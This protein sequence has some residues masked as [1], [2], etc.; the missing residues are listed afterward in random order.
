MGTIRRKD[1]AQ[2]RWKSSETLR[3]GILVKLEAQWIVG[4]VDGE[5]CF[6]VSINKN[7]T[8]TTG[9][10]VL[11]EFTVVQHEQDVKV[12]HALK[13]YFGCGVVRVNRKDKT[14]TRMAYRVRDVR[15]LLDIIS[16][17]FLDHPLKTHKNVEFRKFRKVLL[18]MDK[19]RH[20][21]EEGLEEIRGIVEQMNRKKNGEY[22][23]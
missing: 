10:Q 3:L 11:P 19:G 18:L 1:P 14:S 13:A 9:F 5:G 2:A 23:R 6:H 16:P 4:F 7:D 12:L 22:S 15:H 8:M 20:L 17:F 21:N